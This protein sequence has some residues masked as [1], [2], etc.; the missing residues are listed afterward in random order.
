MQK[1]VL[2]IV[3]LSIV[4]FGSI[5]QTTDAPHVNHTTIYVTDLDRSV[6]FYKDVMMLTVIPEPFHDNRHVWFKIGDHMQLHVVGGAKAISEHDVNIHLAFAVPSLD[7][8]MQH[9]DSKNVKYGNWAGEPK[10]TQER[11]DHILQIYLQD[12]DGYWIEVNNDKF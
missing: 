3:L 11:A 2:A 10:K 9:L 1:T 8:F 4:S 5:A 7:K 12:P 6:A